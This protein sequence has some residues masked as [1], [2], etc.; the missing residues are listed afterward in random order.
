MDLARIPLPR[1]AP[2]TPRP[3]LAALLVAGAFSLQGAPAMSGE[4]FDLLTDG[5]A[6][7]MR[8]GG[9]EAPRRTRAL[10]PVKHDGPEI[11]IHAPRG[12]DL[13]SPVDF[14]VEIVPKDGVE[15]DMTS[16]KIEYRIGPF[17]TDVTDRLRENARMT[18]LRMLAPGAKLPGGEHLLRLTIGDRE[19]RITVAR[20]SFT[21][22]D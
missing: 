8:L 2:M 7:L 4:T 3:I 10:E 9:D 16:L 1:E 22:N 6:R 19:G 12:F 15:P 5:E 21:V 17:W 11:R 20:L 13:A 14:D 18:G